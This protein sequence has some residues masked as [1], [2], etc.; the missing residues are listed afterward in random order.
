MRG[1][2]VLLSALLLAACA[3]ERPPN[4]SFTA[5][6]PGQVR[7]YLVL[8]QA[9]DTSTAGWPGNDLHVAFTAGATDPDQR[10]TMQHVIDSVAARD[11][12]VL[13]LRVTGFAP[14]PMVPGQLNVALH[15]VL[16]GIWAPPDTSDPA[17]RSHKAVHRITYT[18]I[19]PPPDTGRKR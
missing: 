3:A 7:P 2:S 5:G 6:D 1:R 15:P 17:S 16:Q 11:T 4:G 8:K 18:S 13:W 10:A 14:G 12:S 19:A 9:R